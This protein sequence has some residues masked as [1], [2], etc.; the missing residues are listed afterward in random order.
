MYNNHT[1]NNG[2]SLIDVFK[3]RYF[4]FWPLFAILIVIGVIAAWSYLHFTTPVYEVSATLVIKD[5]N[6]GVDD[7]RIMESMNAFNSKKIVE[8]EIEV[9]SSRRLMQ[10]VVKDLHLYALVFEGKGIMESS[11]YL[12]SPVVVSLQNPDNIIYKDKSDDDPEKIYFSYSSSKQQVTIENNSYPINEWVESPYGILK[13]SLNEFQTSKTGQDFYFTLSSPKLVANGLLKNLNVSA[14]DRLSTIVTLKLK[15]PV[16]QRGENIL[17]YLI[18]SYDQ[19]AKSERNTLATN[20]IAFIDDRIT[21]VEAGLNLVERE[22]QQYRSN[23]GVVDLSEQ[24]KLYLQNV[25]DY[26]RQIAD[27]KLQLSILEKVESYVVSKKA[28]G[29]IVPSTLGLKDAVLSQLLEKLYNAEIEY[30]KLKRTTAENNP[31]LASISQEIVKIRPDIL[32]S[33]YNQKANLQ[34][35]LNN[36][37]SSRRKYSSALRTIPENEMDL[38]EISRKKANKDELFSF[39]LQKREE[40]ALSSLVI[41]GDSRIVDMAEASLLPVSP[42]PAI[43]YALAITLAFILGTGYVIGKEVF[44]NK[45]RSR[46][47]IEAVTNTPVICEFSDFENLKDKQLLNNLLHV[48]VFEQFRYL[49][50]S[51]GMFRKNPDKKKILITSSIPGEG[52]SFISTNL[53]HSLAVTGKK[54]VLV[55]FD[56]GNPS[57]T[58]NFGFLDKTGIADYLSGNMEFFEIIKTTEVDNLYILPAGRRMDNSGKLLV[59]D[60]ISGLFASLEEEFDVVVIDTPP[61]DLFS[62]AYLLSEYCDTTILTLR[63]DFTPQNIIKRE[64]QKNK[65]KPLKNLVIAFNGVKPRKMFKSQGSFGYDYK[66]AYLPYEKVLKNRVRA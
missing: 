60:K 39:L 50:V 61:I 30:E 33:I 54:V 21:E 22:E 41:G 26:D 66:R 49:G 35:N 64:N 17:N 63:Y 37:T 4:P 43:I 25:G 15:D 27:I 8:N 9:M 34:E 16:A 51:L 20:T 36:L 28:E 10:Q 58:K 53:A 31:I 1:S 47:E 23:R 24:G 7:S 12:S 38:L 11:A 40:A 48:S 6:K 13:F 14:A 62:D 42:K 55:D 46:G 59:N 57:L 18:Y 32:V 5:E 56:F 65:V 2:E 44:N 29:G 3:T 45:I 19:A 52:K